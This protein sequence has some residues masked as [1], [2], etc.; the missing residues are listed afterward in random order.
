MLIGTPEAWLNNDE[1]REMLSSKYLCKN[2]CCLVV[3]EVHK[4]SWGASSNSGSAFREAFGRI[5]EIRSLCREHLPVLAL[6]ATV[7]I[8]LTELI[9]SSCNLSRNLRTIYTCSDRKNIRLSVVQIKNQEQ[10]QYLLWIV[11]L[12][13]D[14]ECPRCIVYCR[15]VTLCGYVYENIYNLLSKELLPNGLPIGRGARQI[16][17]L[18]HSETLEKNKINV[19]DSF[20]SMEGPLKLVIATSSLG[21]GVNLQGVKYVIHFGPAFDTTDYCQQIGRAGRGTNAQCHAILYFYRQGSSRIT[22]GMK[23]YSKNEDSECLRTLLFTPYNENNK[24]VESLETGHLCCSFCT[25]NCLC[26]N[27]IV[28][29]VYE[30]TPEIKTL[31]PLP[32]Q[33][34]TDEQYVEVQEL[35]LEYKNCFSSGTCLLAS[36]EIVTG[37]SPETLERVKIHL[38]YI[39]SLEY[40]LLEMHI[41]NKDTAREILL[42]IKDVFD[43]I[44]CYT[45]NLN[46]DTSE[47]DD[48]FIF[49][50]Q[51][52]DEFHDFDTD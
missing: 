30:L 8:D 44:E 31:F 38:P 24:V 36:P 28:D 47:V 9:I 39:D 27:C 52:S 35:L 19:L 51:F 23:Q 32:V 14:P 13:V 37:I 48:K 49:S 42:I 33:H 10:L 1:W 18:F 29:Y 3:D 46:M 7:D 16:I 4:V 34:V 26:G 17:S 6:S 2:V 5:S 22:K 20:S 12:L 21:C 15:T 40:V 45:D 50:D 25:K 11:K 43:D 41:L